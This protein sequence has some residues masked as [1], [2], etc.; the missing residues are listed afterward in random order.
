MTEETP[1]WYK[2]QSLTLTEVYI[3]INKSQII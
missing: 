2:N 1:E 3:Y